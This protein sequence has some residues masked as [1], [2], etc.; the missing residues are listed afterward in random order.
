[1]PLIACQLGWITAEVGRQPWVVYKLMRTSNAVSITVGTGELLFSIIMF[2]LIY[3]FL[4]LIF[5][6]LLFRWVKNVPTQ[7][8]GEVAK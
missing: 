6:R 7:T 8:T 3:I 5:L 4:G 1:L 2:I